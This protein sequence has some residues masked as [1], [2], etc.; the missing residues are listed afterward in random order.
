MS[1]IKLSSVPTTS[2]TASTDKLLIV[3]N[4][5]SNSNIANGSPSI[6]SIELSDFASNFKVSNVVPANSSSTGDSGQ[7]S[8]DGNYLYIC[9]YKNTWMRTN[10]NTW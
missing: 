4:A 8:F 5:I 3:Y 10:L 7:I 6:R 9:T 2:N 1:D